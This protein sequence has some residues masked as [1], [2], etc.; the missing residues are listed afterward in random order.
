MVTSRRD[1]HSLGEI[2]IKHNGGMIE[3]ALKMQFFYYE[4][5]NF[6]NSDHVG[7]VWAAEGCRVSG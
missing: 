6:G 1:G 4:K 2:E 3:L 7:A 5:Y